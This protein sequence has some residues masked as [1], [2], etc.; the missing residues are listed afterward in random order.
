MVIYIIDALLK[1]N[2]ELK[3]KVAELEERL[4]IYE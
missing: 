3:N 4:K 2:D 1:E